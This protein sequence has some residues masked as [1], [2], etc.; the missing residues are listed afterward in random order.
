M[1]LRSINVE[2]KIQTEF[3]KYE[4]I[5]PK[6]N[7]KPTS[8]FWGL[9]TRAISLYLKRKPVERMRNPNFRLELPGGKVWA[10][11]EHPLWSW[12]GHIFR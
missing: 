9:S 3:T 1:N 11:E 6:L 7:K 8:A 12:S 2:W 5:L 4:I 10:R